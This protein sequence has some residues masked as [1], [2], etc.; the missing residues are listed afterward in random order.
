MLS[1]ARV[2][3][4]KPAPLPL[5]SG[6]RLG[7]VYHHD[8]RE[9]Q[10]HVGSLHHKQ[11]VCALK[12]SP[13]GRLLS[14]GCSDGLLAIWPH[15]PGVRTQT[16]PL[17]VISQPTA[18]KVRHPVAFQVALHSD[19]TEYP[20]HMRTKPLSQCFEIFL[21]LEFVV[22]FAITLLKDNPMYTLHVS[23]F[24]VVSD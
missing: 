5:C 24:V 20:S 8:V 21:S 6:S 18:V 15:D 23:V 16:Q 17:K 1:N 9:A 10:H 19:I 14:S 4:Q 11:A 12:W 22:D 2:F 3:C 7:R 13:D